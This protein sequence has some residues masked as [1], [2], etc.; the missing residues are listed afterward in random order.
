MILNSNNW[1]IAS[2]GET[3]GKVKLIKTENDLIDFFSGN[4][5]ISK[6]TDVNYAPSMLIASAVITEEGGRYSHAAIFCR[7]NNIPCIVG[8]TGIMDHLSDG[9]KIHINTRI[10]LVEIIEE[11]NN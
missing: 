8:A 3:K 9:D 2:N 10:K 1:R 5:L 7:E 6:Q 4:I 11:G